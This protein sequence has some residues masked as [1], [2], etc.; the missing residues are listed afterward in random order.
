MGA[1]TDILNSETYKKVEEE[2]E[3]FVK[4]KLDGYE[5]GK[6]IKK[7]IRDPVWGSI[8]FSVWE[9]QLIDTPLLQRLRDVYQVGLVY[10]T[11]PAS[12][13]SRFEHSLGVFA[14]ARKMCHS[15]KNNLRDI[16]VN[17]KD[18]KENKNEEIKAIIKNIEEKENSIYLAALLHDVGHCFLSHLSES[19]YGEFEDFRELKKL[20]KD[21][22]DRKTKPHEILSFIIINTKTFKTFF[23]NRIN[24]PDPIINHDVFFQN[25]GRMIVG[26]CIKEGNIKYS[27]LTSIIN[28]PFDAD[29]LDYIKRDSI[30]T[31]LTL[32]YDVERLLNKIIV[33]NKSISNRNEYRL[34][35]QFNGITA[36]EE[37]TFCKIMLHSYLYYHQK[38]LTADAM[39]KD[40][41]QGLC[42]MGIINSYADFL[43]YTDSDIFILGKG[44]NVDKFFNN[45]SL[46]LGDLADRIRNRRFPKRCF[47]LSHTNVKNIRPEKPDNDLHLYCQKLIDKCKTDQITIEDVKKDIQIYTRKKTRKSHTLLDM[48]IKYLPELTYDD[49]LKKREELFYKLVERYESEGKPVDFSLFDIFIVFPKQVNYDMFKDEKVIIGKD[50]TE[51]FTIDDFVKL[52]DWASSFNSNKWRGYV[53]VS[54]N[55]DRS[56][57]F[58]VA[59]E[60]ILKGKAEIRNPTAYI[61]G[62]SV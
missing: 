19:I 2:V 59:Q 38:V 62:I 33:H 7:T 48:L 34:A 21:N 24:Y 55:I 28:G 31:G 5:P 9:I 47:E 51:F 13:H 4:E 46:D 50:N 27:Y 8:E 16:P 12:R 1:L 30:T 14:A 54:E 58:K 10:F 17:D 32:A 52:D 29:K 41:V 18:G 25:V 42:R 60:Y 57:A 23:S 61:R 43:R 44:K 3:R 11:Y 36:V 6:T 56:I 22:L 45:H 26:D 15:I 49:L 40:Y 39:V 35:I 20:F 53:F 37:L